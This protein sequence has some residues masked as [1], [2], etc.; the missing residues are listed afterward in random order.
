MA[1]IKNIRKFLKLDNRVMQ[2]DAEFINS[3]GL[4]VSEPKQR[5]EEEW[6][7]CI[8]GYHISVN[9]K[10]EL[11]NSFLPQGDAP[12]FSHDFPTSHL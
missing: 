4:Y 2:L 11:H 8:L 1:I 10:Y 7:G 5:T 9:Q 12:Q 6:Q 3:V